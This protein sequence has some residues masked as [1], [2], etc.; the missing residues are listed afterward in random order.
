M[1]RREDWDEKKKMRVRRIV[2]LSFAA[3]FLLLVMVFKWINNPSMIGV[4]LKVAAYTYGP[5][6]GL[7]AFGIL[8]T[9]QV[10]DRIV[11]Y[12]CF[13]A[14]IICYII[15]KF[16]SDIFG[17]YEV[18]LEL[19]IINGLLTFIGLYIISRPQDIEPE[20]ERILSDGNR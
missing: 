8:T 6:L 18:G 9:R 10:K 14:P 12:I 13:A 2:H 5:L 7:F 3:I 4:I 20:V 19:L 17:H 1:K 15:D 16:Q 11:P